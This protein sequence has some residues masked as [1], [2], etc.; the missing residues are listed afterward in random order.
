MREWRRDR[1]L[2]VLL[3]IIN[4]IKTPQQYALFAK[5]QRLAYRELPTNAPAEDHKTLEP[6]K[7]VVTR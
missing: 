2:G 3:S 7:P 4:Y 6:V 5:F 1:L